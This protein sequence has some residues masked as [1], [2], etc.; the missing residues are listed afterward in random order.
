MFGPLS[1]VPPALFELDDVRVRHLREVALLE[2]DVDALAFLRVE[3]LDRFVVLDGRDVFGEMAELHRFV[4]GDQEVGEDVLAAFVPEYP[5][6]VLEG[7]WCVLVLTG[8][9]ILD[10]TRV[11][12]GRSIRRRR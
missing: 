6:H 8:D 5:E 11:R 4:V 9:W 10:A 1:M 7:E 12:S 3:R 2:G